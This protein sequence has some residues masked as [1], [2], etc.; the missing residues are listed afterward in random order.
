MTIVPAERS[1]KPHIT[2]PPRPGLLA[3]KRTPRCGSARRGRE[4]QRVQDKPTFGKG[5]GWIAEHLPC[6]WSNLGP[7][8]RVMLRNVSHEAPSNANPTAQVSVGAYTVHLKFFSPSLK[9]QQSRLADV[10]FLPGIRGALAA[11]GK[12][13]FGF[14][15][16]IVG[17][18]SPPGIFAVNHR[19]TV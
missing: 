4:G 13:G 7:N 14:A 1:D 9:V 5:Q 6:Q 3:I 10:D 12:K 11:E 17:G 19:Q 15:R 18:H 8:V 2:N 16:S